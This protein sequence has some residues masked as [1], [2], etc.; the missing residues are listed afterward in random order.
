MGAVLGHTDA[1]K[2]QCTDCGKLLSFGSNKPGN[3]TVHG[4]KCNLEKMP[5]RRYGLTCIEESEIPSTRTICKTD[6]TG[7]DIGGAL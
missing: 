3:Q 5:Q 2:A 7:R 4:L 1:C 6:E